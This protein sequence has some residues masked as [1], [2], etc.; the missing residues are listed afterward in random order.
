MTTTV[1]VAGGP[2]GLGAQLA[3]A[4]LDR[5]HA[6]V[7]WPG[8]RGGWSG[9]DVIA[10]AA[11]GTG[12]A[13]VRSLAPG[14]PLDEAGPVEMA[15]C[16][17][18]GT[19]AVIAR[20]CRTDGSTVAAVLGALSAL[21]AGMLC[22]VGPSWLSAPLP[23]VP[24]DVTD[25]YLRQREAVGARCAAAGLAARMLTVGAIVSDTVPD[26]GTGGLAHFI[27]TVLTLVAEIGERSPGYLNRQPLRFLASP[28][29][30]LGLL[31]AGEAVQ[32]LLRAA[33]GPAG[34]PAG[35]AASHWFTAADLAARLTAELGVDLL[36][37]EAPAE[38]NPVDRLFQ[39]RLGTVHHELMAATRFDAETRLSD[40]DAAQYLARAIRAAAAAMPPRRPSATSLPPYLHE[41]RAGPLFY[42]RAGHLGTPIVLLGA[43]G[44]GPCFWYRLIEQLLPRR[45]ILWTGRIAQ[46]SFA[47]HLA[48]LDAV[49]AHENVTA[50][51][52]VG[53]CSGAH[54]A[55]EYA[56]T[57]SA[58]VVTATL[59]NGALHSPDDDPGL[60]TAF[61]RNA[62]LM[63]GML[64]RKP[65]MASTLARTVFAAP[66]DAHAHAD[67]DENDPER[68]GRAV[69]TWVDPVLRGEI[70]ATL[71]QPE[72]LL[73]HAR[74]RAE[75]Q[76]RD[77][78]RDPAQLTVPILCIGAE[79]DDV[80]SP[81]LLQA[82]ARRLPNARYAEVQGGTHFLLHDRPALV[83]TLVSSFTADP[84]C[85]GEH[86]GE[87]R[88]QRED[89]GSAGY[90]MP[91]R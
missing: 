77:P 42:H 89:T 16:L 61:R 70:Q 29:A 60:V 5:G 3:A 6:V 63:C 7:V 84:A 90:V 52:L 21:R 10:L 20:G 57:R 56:R 85:R 49:L 33:A 54:T 44:T 39:S 45:V 58:A 4:H 53:W 76:A 78:L 11:G 14:E 46:V 47:A 66:A 34:V 62:D 37:T 64:V 38:L 72:D 91:L 9:S 19:D 27:G 68:Q 28:G 32:A 30:G 8:E 80:V 75:L 26:S 18:T 12:G 71:R 55:L 86:D 48:D 31:P 51:H 67:P 83:A 82:Q 74:L 23:D 88:W 24:P 40:Q 13:R 59:L 1:L 73:A 15:W 2:R 41:V 17:A 87:V 35:P 69:L 22:Y 50:C 79:Y 36:A 43:F 25:S 65:S 81:R